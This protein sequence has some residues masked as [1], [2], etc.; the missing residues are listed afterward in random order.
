MSRPLVF[1]PEAH[2][3]INDTYRW[4]ERQRSGLGDDFLDALEDVFRRLRTNP[5]VHPVISH[6]VRRALIRRFPYKVFYRVHADRVEILAVHH[7]RRDPKAWQD[8][9]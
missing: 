9:V 3:D 4:Y 6:G 5:E 8:R 7:G 2:D 1:P